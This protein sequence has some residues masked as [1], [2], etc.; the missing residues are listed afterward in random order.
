MA[1]ECEWKSTHCENLIK[2]FNFLIGLFLVA[3]G[4]LRFIFSSQL[5]NFQDFLLSAYYM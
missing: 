4:V 2:I 5:N 1:C 3:L